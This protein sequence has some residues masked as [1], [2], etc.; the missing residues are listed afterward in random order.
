MTGR[1]LLALSGRY[2]KES[3][4]SVLKRGIV[5]QPWM[6]ISIESYHIVKDCI[7][8]VLAVTLHLTL[9]APRTVVGQEP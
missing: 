2:H 1:A 3:H 9:G 8:Y 6:E 4:V 7:A 5:S